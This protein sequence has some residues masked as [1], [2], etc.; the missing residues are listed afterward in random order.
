MHTG[1]R[2]VLNPLNLSLTSFLSYMTDNSGV[3]ALNGQTLC[4]TAYYSGMTVTSCGLPLAIGGTACT[5]CNVCGSLPG[6]P[7]EFQYSTWDCNNVA[8]GDL[9]SYECEDLDTI[10]DLEALSLLCKPSG[11]QPVGWSFA[12]ALGVGMMTLL[13][14]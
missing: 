9:V 13:Y 12:A 14:I 2:L 3:G 11:G 6:F 4:S 5:A 8:G 7:D 10:E 1:L